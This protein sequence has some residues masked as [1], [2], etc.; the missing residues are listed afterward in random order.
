MADDTK[1]AVKVF[2]DA[3]IPEFEKSVEMFTGQSVTVER[4]SETRPGTAIHT[5]DSILWQGQ[6]FEHAG[7][8][9]VWV[10]IPIQ[11]CMALTETSEEDAPAREALYRELLK[12]SFEGAAHVLSTGRPQRIVCKQAIEGRVPPS[13]LP[14]VEAA[15][16]VTG[17]HERAPILLSLESAFAALLLK[18]E[19][20]P[21]ERPSTEDMIQESAQRIDRLVDLELPI[22][23]ILGRAKL[24]I[25]D[26]LKLTVGSLVELDRRVGE[27]VEIVV[28]NAVV[29]RG[30]VVSLSG[31]YGVRIQEVISRSDRMALQATASSRSSGFRASQ[32]SVN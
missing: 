30:E 31:N 25:R 29:A 32:L 1:Q 19:Q 9:S 10:G 13:D 14:G 11:T 22:A 20:R 6:V 7:I 3:W 8:G 5:P 12:Q 27:P 16:I 28:H 18:K 17:S 21:S 24:Q 15:W 23:V 4:A 26:V 2:L